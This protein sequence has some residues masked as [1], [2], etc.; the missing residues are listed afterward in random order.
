MTVQPRPPGP[1]IQ[2][3][4]PLASADKQFTLLVSNLQP[5]P[6]KVLCRSGGFQPEVEITRLTR[7]GENDLSVIGIRCGPRARISC[8]ETCGQSLKGICHRPQ[9]SKAR[10]TRLFWSS[11]K[12]GRKGLCF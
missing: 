10:R 8:D 2:Q 3:I 5:S 12:K 7:A 9:V 11:C 4:R 1:I 6:V